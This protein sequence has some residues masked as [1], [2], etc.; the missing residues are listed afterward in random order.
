MKYFIRDCNG[1]IV[2]N[3]KGYK[4]FKGANRQ[5]DIIDSKAYE[6]IYHA[7]DNRVDKSNKLLLTVKQVKRQ[8]EIHNV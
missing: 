4:T 6:Q 2:G 5:P 8:L 7:F 1:D 3:T